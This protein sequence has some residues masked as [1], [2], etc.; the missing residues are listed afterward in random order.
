MKYYK[1]SKDGKLVCLLCSYYCD[2]KENQIG[3][4]GV[5][6]HIDDKIENLVYGHISAFNIDPIEKKPLYHFLPTSKSLSLGTVGCNFHCNFCQNHGI[7]Q[8]KK[9]D[10]SRYT[11]AKDVVNIAIEKK[12]AS[13]SYTYNE[14]TIFY[15]YA[16]DI[17]LEAKKHGI[18]SVFVSNGF[19]SK[20]V[21]KDMIGVIDA[22]NVDLKSF[23]QKY[24][25]KALG[26]NLNQVLENLIEIKKNGIWLEITTL[27]VP[28]KNDSE[29]EL[30]SI[31]KFIKENLGVN[32]PWHISAFHPDYKEQS[33]P[34]T[35][36][37]S[38]IKA[39][40]IAISH[41]LKYVYIGNIGHE[42][43]TKCPK[44]NSELIK[45]EYF[46]VKSYS[47]KNSKCPECNHLLDGIFWQN[48]KEE[49]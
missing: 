10:K 28:S 32:T 31:V 7:S 29:E 46:N 6:K 45:R 48:H 47:L 35:P 39:K 36:L 42:N 34:R 11:S 13:I 9:I 37:E 8:E 21:I 49:F 15:P 26:G 33:L 3:I 16:K 44:C 2:L 22:I 43:I 24:Y 19:E 30:T 17:A 27:I 40:E 14:P 38:L 25:K 20:E 23:S 4:C 1:P 5:N 18:K 12:C 41:G